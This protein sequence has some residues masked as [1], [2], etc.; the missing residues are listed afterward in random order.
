VHDD[1]SRRTEKGWCID[2]PGEN[3]F[4][5]TCKTEIEEKLGFDGSLW[6]RRRFALD[7]DLMAAFSEHEIFVRIEWRLNKTWRFK[8]IEIL[9]DDREK[10][11]ADFSIP[12]VVT[13]PSTIA[14]VMRHFL[15][16][17]SYWADEDPEEIGNEFEVHTMEAELSSAARAFLELEQFFRES[18]EGL[19][20]EFAE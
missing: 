5:K 2:I 9:F 7:Y 20:S 13:Y 4:D 19:D 14:D 1:T 6:I 15:P 16:W 18:W 10:E 8:E 17:L 11:Y 12:V 3:T